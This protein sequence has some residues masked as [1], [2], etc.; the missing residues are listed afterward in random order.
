MNTYEV[1]F[2]FNGKYY[3]ELITTTD[4]IKARELVRGRYPGA[5]I[6]GV[7]KK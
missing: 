7:H 1:H 2:R 6:T 3:K 5:V 4:G